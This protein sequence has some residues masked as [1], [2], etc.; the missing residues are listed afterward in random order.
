[1]NNRLAIVLIFNKERERTQWTCKKNISRLLEREM[2]V[3]LKKTKEM[4]RQTDEIM[5]TVAFAINW[6][7]S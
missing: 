2:N 6:G 5:R 1:M 4:I 3:S 7:M